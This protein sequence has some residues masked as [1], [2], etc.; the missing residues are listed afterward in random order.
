KSGGLLLRYL[1]K[2]AFL[3]EVITIN[4]GGRSIADTPTYARI[5]D[6][7]GKI[8]LAC[9][10][11]PASQVS[12]T[13]SECVEAGVPAGIIYSAGFSESG[14]EGRQRQRELDQR[15]DGF[16]YIGPNSLGVVSTHR[17]LVISAAMGLEGETLPVGS[18]G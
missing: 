12:A 14:E 3:G 1:K 5:T 15:A 8:D 13:V 16:R 17:P 18:V 11:V 10:A 6:A 9:I 7:P 4:P 2:H